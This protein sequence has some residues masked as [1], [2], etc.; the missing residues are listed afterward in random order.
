MDRIR[1]GVIGTSGIAMGVHLPAY[2]ELPGVEIIAVCDIDENSLQRAASQYNVAHAF[3]DYRKM[4]E[5]KDLDAVTVAT[6]NYLHAP[7]TIAALNAGKHVLCEKPLATNATE[8]QA[9][10]DAAERANRVLMVGVNNRFRDES[11]KLKR[12]IDSGGLGRIY[13]G[14]T[15]WIR[16]RGVPYWGAWF[17]DKAKAGGGP[18][19]DLG[20]HMLDLAWWLMGKPEPVSV[21]GSTY[22]EIENY[23]IVEW[24][25]GD[26][27]LSGAPA[28]AQERKTYDVEDAAFAFIRFSNNAT[29]S[30][31]VTWALNTNKEHYYCDLYGNK[32]GASLWPLTIYGEQD[33]VLT[34]THIKVDEKV[35]S[36]KAEVA[37]FI[38]CIRH[39]RTPMCP[40][41]DG[42]AVMR[43]LDAIYK[44]AESG[45]EVRLSS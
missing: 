28:R 17:M 1:V 3:T 36:H 11:L 45:R 6:P 24:D 19:I 42:V 4:L 27:V 40:A 32:A 44:S 23:H 14:R 31:A 37:H 30:L 21:V 2:A 16:R 10:A 34:D 29:L 22:H 7:I 15:G 9:M 5:L 26:P 41:S 39:G 12:I 8:A 35:K 25:T 33:G 18:L 38:D 20:V 13:A 43:M